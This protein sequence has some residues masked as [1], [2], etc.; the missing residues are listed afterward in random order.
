MTRHTQKQNDRTDSISQLRRKGY[1]T[2]TNTNPGR[3]RRRGCKLVRAAKGALLILP[4][5]LTLL[6]LGHHTTQA[7]SLTPASSCTAALDTLTSEWRSIGFVEPGKP[8]QMI[9]YGRHGYQ[10]TGGQ[11]NYMAQQIRTAAHN[12]ER[13]RDEE[14]LRHVNIVRRILSHTGPV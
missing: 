1:R 2:M 12:C 9:V 3:P 4:L 11:Y 10:T 13:G 6:G 14:A 5:G 8:A 7:Q